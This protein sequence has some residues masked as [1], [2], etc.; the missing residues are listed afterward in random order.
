MPHPSQPSFA[1]PPAPAY[2]VALSGGADSR[3]LLELTVEAARRTDTPVMAAHLH[4][5]IRG[6][7]ADR[8]EAFCRAVCAAMAVPLTVEHAD[9]PTIA[10]ASGESLETAARRVRYEFLRRVMMAHRIPLLLTAHHADDQLETLLLRFLRGSGTRGMGG[11]PPRR[12]IGYTPD[13]A[14]LAVFRPLLHWSRR[15]ILAACTARS[16]DFVT[17]STNLTDDCTRNRLRHTVIPALTAIAGEDKPQKAAERLS[18]AAREDE[19]ALAVM[20]RERYTAARERHGSP[21]GCAGSIPTT[22]VAQEMP[23]IGKRM[24]LFA[25]TDFLAGCPSND[26]T[27]TTAFDA[28]AIPA[29]RTLSAADLTPPAADRTL[30]A[31]HLDA[32]FALCREGREGAVSDPLPNGVRAILTDG[33]LHFQAAIPPAAPASLPAPRPLPEGQTLWDAGDGLSPCVSILVESA[34]SPLPPLTGSTVW[35]SAL[36]PADALPLP[37]WARTRE[38]GDI[39]LSHGMNKK[40]KK[41]LT[42]KHIPPILRERLPLFCLPDRRTPLWYPGVAFRDGYPAPKEG[43]CLRITVYLDAD[44]TPDNG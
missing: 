39:I 42:D 18:A 6:E 23:A 1:L 14:P 10:T 36:F 40:L 28:E 5:G 43:P 25:Y 16:L 24:L 27:G 3:L 35:A 15:D 33:Q 34:P 9:I 38:A 32:L 44:A 30:S 2:L 26:Q 31:Y 4:H 13:G 22:A 41:L 8:D 21:R 17:D 37:L 29:G 19:E 20:A 11:I 7:E 12:V